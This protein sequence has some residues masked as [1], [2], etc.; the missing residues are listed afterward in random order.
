[1]NAEATLVYVAGTSAPLVADARAAEARTLLAL[2]AAG[3]RE[4]LGALYDLFSR[5]IHALALWRTGRRDDADDVV[6][7]VFV[8]LATTGADLARVREPRTYLLAMAHRACV[9]RLRGRR[10]DAGLDDVALVETMPLAPERALDAERVS[11]ALSRLPA[12][13]RAAIYMHHFAD[14]PFREI[15]RVTGVP[16]FTAASRYRLGM[17]RLQSLLG[18]DR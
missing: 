13:Q 1:M 6:Q 7:D 9:D 17:K 2:V 18:A 11:R 15:G 16:T 12:K 10:N 8:K 4:P 3:D 14:L 5:E